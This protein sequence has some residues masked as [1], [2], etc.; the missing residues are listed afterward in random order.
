MVKSPSEWV[1]DSI[2]M[3]YILS[4]QCFSQLLHPPRN[5]VPTGFAFDFYNHTPKAGCAQEL[6]PH[7]KQMRSRTV[8]PPIKHGSQWLDLSRKTL[9]RHL[10]DISARN[11][12]YPSFQAGF[13]CTSSLLSVFM[14]W[15]CAWL[16][17]RESGLNISQ[18]ILC[19]KIPHH[20]VCAGR[21]VD[22]TL[23]LCLTKEH[24][25]CPKR[26]HINL[27]GSQALKGPSWFG[28]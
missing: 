13:F 14:A 3:D 25:H 7:I 1:T 24:E 26:Q 15:P 17:A 12:H 21:S 10:T 28:H 11:Q 2:R 19:P 23:R 4:C 8:S 9:Y 5:A 16:W 6:L 22:W 20:L 18:F 27:V